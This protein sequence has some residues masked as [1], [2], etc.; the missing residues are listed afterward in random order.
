MDFKG[1]LRT[2]FHSSILPQVWDLHI[3]N[4]T[5]CFLKCFEFKLEFKDETDTTNRLPLVYYCNVCFFGWD[6][7]EIID[8]FVF[9]N[10]I[11]I[12]NFKRQRQIIKVYLFGTARASK[13]LS[14]K[15]EFV[16]FL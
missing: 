13:I 4:F 12:L 3:F 15:I 10:R 9:K 6:A 14:L 1:I 11:R 8:L 2:L 5:K 16:I 7:H